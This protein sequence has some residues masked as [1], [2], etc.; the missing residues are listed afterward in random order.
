MIHFFENE[1]NTVFAVQSQKD[2][3][4]EDISKLNWL[5]GNSNKID[6]SVLNTIGTDFF[7]G[8][9]ATMIT[10]WSTNA[11]EI[12]QNMG[13]SGIVRIEEFFKVNSDFTD[14]DP[15]L[16][17]KYVELYQDIFTINIQPEAILE[18]DD[19]AS[20]NQSEGLALSQEE[21]DYLNDLSTK[22]GRKLTD[23]EV[24]GFSQANSEHCRHKIFNGTFVIDGV[25]MPSSLFKLIKKTSAE[26][27]NDI[28][29]A[30]KDNVAFIK[31]PRVQ[32]FAPKSPE[33]ADFYET[34]D[35]D[36]VLSLKAETHNFPTTVEPFNGAATGSGGE[37]RD[38]LAGGQG[39]IPL[40]G[41]AVYMTSYSRLSEL[42]PWE[43]G[44]AERKWLYQ[45]P[46]DILIKASNGASD[47]GNKFGQP[48][49]TGSI[50][51]FEHEEN[52]RKLGYDKVIMQAGG[53][54]YGKL[55]QAIKK[56]PKAGD[57]I[58][59]LG[60][61]NYRIGMGGAAVSSA[62][63]G[64][65]SSGIELNA[66]QR[67][68]PEMQKRAA[69][70]IRGLV[71]SDINPIVSIHDHGAGGHLNC[72]SELIEETGGLIDLDKL[73]IGD[74]TLSAKEI[75]GNESQERMGLVIGQK[76]IELLQ[77]IAD[78][79]RSPMY[80][81]GDVTDNHR[82]T[83]ESKTTG[84][85]PMDFALE[86]FFGS[87]PKTIMTDKTV[88][89]NYAE[90]NYSQEKI[91]TY[92][93]QVL[94]LEAVACKDWLTNKV[95]RCV[96]GKVA[97]QQC[98]GPLQLPLNN[99]G[100]M[101]LDYLGKE[102]IATSIGHS[103]IA[104]LIDPVAGTRTA[105]GEA[106]SNIIWAPIK[107]G[108]KGISLSANW[109]WACKNEGEDAR[110]YAAVKSCSDFAIELGINIP[111]GK[112]SLSMKQKYPN[113]EVIAPGTV[114]ISAGGNCTDIKKVV[115]P[116]LQIDGGSIYYINLSQDD[117][118][119]GGTS[120]AQVLNTIGTEVPT[121]KDSKFFKNAF[122]SIQEL[123][124]DDQ[125]IAGHDIGSGGLIT[126]LLEMCFAN[127]N[128]GASIDLSTFEE[129]DLIKIL[130]AENIGIVFQVKNDEEIEK[131]LKA[132]NINFHK[133]GKVTNEATLDFG[134]LTLDIPKYRDIWYKTSFLL[135]QKQS[136]NGMAKERFENFDKQPLQFSFPKHFTGKLSSPFGADR[137]GAPKAAIIREKGSNS[138]REMANAMYLAGFEVKDIHMTDLI[139]GRENLEDI[140]FIGAVGG[141]SNSDVLGSAKGWA[142]AFLYNEKAKTALANFFKREDTLSVGICNGCQLF[143]ELEVINPEHE[144][145]GK[146]KHNTSRKHESGFTS[147][148][149]QNNN[150]VMLSTLAGATLGVWISH[151]EGKFNLPLPE[152]NYNIVSKYAYADYPANPNGSDYNTAMLC[153]K[154]GRHLVMMPHIERSTFQWNWAN[155]P[156]N[157]NDEV[158]PWHEAFVNA[159]KWI[160]TK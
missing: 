150:S 99:C 10:P 56:K 137:E 132:N 117:F 38:R 81:V 92:L 110:L 129:K 134:H 61:D 53:I 106:L 37:I 62:D 135:D 3:S 112:D 51:T 96:G 86:D 101:A 21:V 130:F 16:S 127:N 128:L 27:P 46:M 22:I 39:S 107:D 35:F 100:V 67:S 123:I 152:E 155:Y 93:E 19:I 55:D 160:E 63:T 68:N 45:T 33:K 43:N 116:V 74:P 84:E 113:D 50:L 133:L 15:M 71:E 156:K 126:T 159:R 26:N 94:Q 108:M 120:F 141:F 70:A 72:L 122:N 57:K 148:T 11:V 95:D 82:F 59:I 73:P 90:L 88:T 77:K 17:Q 119:L 78:R 118:K 40:A 65:F 24:F 30:Y 139:S 7:I 144:V 102:G 158:S 4:A 58:V 105:I 49:I 69:N 34:K 151:G 157:R 31:G 103:P 54:G 154:T 125:I 104:S 89:I 124:L 91:A 23:S 42:K 115:E 13:I 9:R 52:N 109:M 138:E 25:E 5:F 1:T 20:Y 83:F 76:D 140:Q 87:S 2:F 114:I 12:T 32:Q 41:T 6:K 121:I 18:I 44:M 28:V 36:S 8:P 97:K 47:F 143:M 60:G 146:M 14:F 29:S 147:V 64:A 111:T 75:I 142:G 80:Q 131:T 66:I 85:K 48:L 98:A 149:I 136:K 145:H 79:E 153:D